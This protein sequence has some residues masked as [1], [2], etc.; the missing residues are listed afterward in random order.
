MYFSKEFL[1]IPVLLFNKVN[2]LLGN[3]DTEYTVT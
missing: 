3:V 2:Y 1:S